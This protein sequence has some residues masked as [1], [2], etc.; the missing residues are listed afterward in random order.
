MTIGAGTVVSNSKLLPKNHIHIGRNSFLGAG[1]VLVGDCDIGDESGVFPMSVLN[2]ESVPSRVTR[3]QADVNLPARVKDGV[4]L[5][6]C[7]P[8]YEINGFLVRVVLH[9]I[10]LGLITAF[11]IW[12][13]TSIARAN[14]VKN[15]CLALQITIV[16]TSLLFAAALQV[17]VLYIVLARTSVPSSQRSIHALSFRVNVYACHMAQNNLL[18]AYVFAFLSG[19]YLSNLV[20]RLAGCQ[21]PVFDSI[22]LGAYVHD[23]KLTFLD[24]GVVL[25]RQSTVN[26]HRFTRR[27]VEYGKLRFVC[28]CLLI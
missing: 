2:G 11:T 8:L 18:E 1:T 19:T 3:F 21:L 20:Y 24:A 5:Q 28:A 4:A 13:G 17:I 27:F 12:L 9:W 22:I 15:A 10:P 16:M 26:S 25:E 14:V 6:S 23:P 7:L